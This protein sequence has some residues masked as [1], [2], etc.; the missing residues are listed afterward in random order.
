MVQLFSKVYGN[1]YYFSLGF[2]LFHGNAFSETVCSHPASIITEPLVTPFQS[3]FRT[4]FRSNCN[5]SI[6]GFVTSGS[7][8]WYGTVVLHFTA[9]DLI[10]SSFNQNLSFLAFDIGTC[11]KAI[12]VAVSWMAE[13]FGGTTTVV[14]CARTSY[15]SSFP[16]AVGHIEWWASIG[17]ICLG[18]CKWQYEC[19][20]PQH[21]WFNQFYPLRIWRN[22]EIF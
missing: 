12:G 8:S 13:P 2:L 20:Q 15:F 14:V 6:L 3:I 11:W 18:V 22:C 17:V 5:K 16:I 10:P 19:E 1:N 9:G 21:C 4:I 7:R